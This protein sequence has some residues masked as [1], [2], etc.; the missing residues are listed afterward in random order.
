MKKTKK[1]SYSR[2]TGRK[3]LKRRKPKIVKTNYK[4][5]RKLINVNGYNILLLDL[6]KAKLVQV[7]CYILGSCLVEDKPGISHLLEHILTTAWKKCKPKTCDV[8]W[9][10]YG[11]YSNATTSSFY[12]RYWINGLHKY[13]DT[14]VEY[15]F[16]IMLNP[17]INNKT[18]KTERPAVENEL[19][20]YLNDP[21]SKLYKAIDKELYKISNLIYS[22]DWKKQLKVLKTITLRE[23]QEMYHRMYNKHNMLFVISGNI[24][25]I[26]DF[27]FIKKEKIGKIQKQIEKKGLIKVEDKYDNCF[28]N[29]K[30]IIFVKDSN[31]KNTTINIVFHLDIFPGNKDYYY[32]KIIKDVM[33]GAIHSLLLKELRER[34]KLVYSIKMSSYLTLCGTINTISVSTLDKNIDKVLKKVFKI[35]KKYKKKNVSREKLLYIKNKYLMRLIRKHPESNPAMVSNHYSLQYLFQLNKK[36]KTIMDINEEIKLYENLTIAKI[37]KYIKIVFNL[38]NC[39]VG[40]HGKKEVKFNISNF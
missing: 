22:G 3:T 24:G 4:I 30:K 8:F 20:T 11:A 25:H 7:E 2:K 18:L 29:G 21:V 19:T 13:L 10:K 37:K 12:K 23:V 34:L 40:Y 33:T 6:P 16:S 35:I 14:M 28:N 32:F 39:I 26:K 38:D 15:I 5:K 17:I 36:R 9:E 1:T 31:A 27:D